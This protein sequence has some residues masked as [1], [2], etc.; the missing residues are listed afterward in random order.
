[1]CAMVSV[2]VPGTTVGTT[3]PGISGTA[4]TWTL[5]PA[6]INF[7]SFNR[8]IGLVMSKTKQGF[9]PLIGP[10]QKKLILAT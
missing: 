9:T 10:Q 3:A 5:H 2:T 7:F 8:F 4:N 1:M 6:L